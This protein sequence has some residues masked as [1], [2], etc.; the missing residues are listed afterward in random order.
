MPAKVTAVNVV[1]RLRPQN[2]RPV[3]STAIDKRPVDGPVEVGELGLAGDVQCDTRHHGGVHQA[4][5]AFADEEAQWWAGL[6]GRSITPGTFGENLRTV[7][8]DVDGAEIGEQWQLGASGT[9]PLLEVTSPRT[10]C[11]TFQ[12][13]MEEPRW[14]RRFTEHGRPGAYLRVLRPGAVTA[15][16]PV[17]VVHR[18]GHGITVAAVFGVPDPTEMARLLELGDA[19]LRLS[20]ALRTAAR[21]AAARA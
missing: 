3:P 15:G 10:P 7:G 8:V 20:P 1:A 14:V 6:L 13:W 19:G 5:Y 16:D 21:R 4:V 9:G 11:R 12:A 17:E 2:F 18:P